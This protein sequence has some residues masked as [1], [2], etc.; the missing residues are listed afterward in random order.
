[1]DTGSILKGSILQKLKPTNLKPFLSEIQNRVHSAFPEGDPR[2]IASSLTSEFLLQRMHRLREEIKNKPEY[3]DLLLPVWT[4]LGFD[5][6]EIYLDAIRIRCVPDKFHENQNA[7]SVGYIHRDPWYANPQCQLNFWIPI[8][9][10][11]QGSGFRIYPTYFDMGIKNNSNTFNYPEW[12][13][14]G[15]FQSMASNHL[16]QQVFPAPLNSP[17]EDCPIDIF[18]DVG[19]MILFCSHH[20]HGTSPNTSG[21]SRFTLEVRFVLQSHLEDRLGPKKI[22]NDS[23]GTTLI[24]MYDLFHKKPVS[25]RLIKHY[26]GAFVSQ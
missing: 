13:E 6:K 23:Q 3:L 18:G 11:G 7:A 1:M 9:P 25:E 5:L 21:K 19:E 2:I 15:G 12:L 4:E 14:L 20:L 17:V 22:D 26:E 8:F 10:V 24:H 16:K